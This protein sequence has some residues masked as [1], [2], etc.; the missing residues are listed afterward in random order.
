M[1]LLG[2]GNISA[3]LSILYAWNVL[4]SFCCSFMQDLFSYN[5]WKEN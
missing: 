5:L 1:G 4:K 2:Q 3:C